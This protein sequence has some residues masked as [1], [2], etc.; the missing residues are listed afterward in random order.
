MDNLSNLSYEEGWMDAEVPARSS[1]EPQ[2]EQPPVK[3]RSAP[4]V[5]IVQTALCALI[6]LAAYIFSQFGGQLYDDIRAWYHTELN[7]EIMLSGDFG[8]FKLDKSFAEAAD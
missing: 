3:K 7:D 6:V 1:P 4:V 2:P 5:L 8:T